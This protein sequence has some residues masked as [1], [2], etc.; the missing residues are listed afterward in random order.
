MNKINNAV[1]AIIANPVTSN[2]K[3]IYVMFEKKRCRNA[4]VQI[5]FVRRIARIIS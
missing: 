4:F 2:L 1:M 3:F 5:D